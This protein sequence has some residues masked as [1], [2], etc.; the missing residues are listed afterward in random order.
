MLLGFS[1][2]LTAWS[3]DAHWIAIS[4]SFNSLRPSKIPKTRRVKL[5]LKPGECSHPSGG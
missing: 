2:G 3:V 5:R 4:F 1:P